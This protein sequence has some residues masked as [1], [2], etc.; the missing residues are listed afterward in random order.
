MELCLAGFDEDLQ[1]N[2]SIT[3]VLGALAPMS[4]L[5]SVSLLIVGLHAV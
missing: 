5:Q 4:G 3:D 2:L 1:I